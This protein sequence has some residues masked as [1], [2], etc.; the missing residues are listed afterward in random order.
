VGA[1]TQPRAL[2]PR[3]FS[4]V[5]RP[6][7]LQH[8]A[9]S[10]H[11]PAGHSGP[12]PSC[13]AVGGGDSGDHV[14]ASSA[15]PVVAV[16]ES[17]LQQPTQQPQLQRRL[18]A[19]QLLGVTLAAVAHHVTAPISR[20]AAVT[21]GKP[22]TA[23]G[24]ASG[25]CPSVRCS[26]SLLALGGAGR[27]SARVI[28]TRRSIRSPMPSG[29]P[30]TVH[31]GPGPLRAL[32]CGLNGERVHAR[33]QCGDPRRTFGRPTTWTQMTSRKSPGQK[34]RRYNF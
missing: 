33:M 15:M 19:C 12:T 24:Q 17:A 27:F 13:E 23:T 1:D 14:G 25:A 21:N 5:A 30:G 7:R 18:R 4:I 31:S 2:G 10:L 16:Q 22:S 20:R 26:C 28:C 32:V 34:P 3:S 6:R 29:G 11:R 8:F 9:R